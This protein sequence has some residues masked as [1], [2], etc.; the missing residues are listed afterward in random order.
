[1]FYGHTAGAE[2]VF[3]LFE[4]QDVFPVWSICHAV[5]PRLIELSQFCS[6]YF[7]AFPASIKRSNAP[8]VECRCRQRQWD[9]CGGLGTVMKKSAKVGVIRIIRYALLVSLIS[10]GAVREAAISHSTQPQMGQNLFVPFYA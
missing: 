7:Y 10:Q 6:A 8:V 9:K 2:K 5:S 4:I 3:F 1:L